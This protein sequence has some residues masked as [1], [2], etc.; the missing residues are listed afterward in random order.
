MMLDIQSVTEEIQWLGHSIAWWNRWVIGGMAATALAAAILV[1]AQLMVNRESKALSDGQD[2][3]LKLKDE[4]LANELSDKGLLIAQANERAAKAD[5]K[6]AEANRG[7]EEARRETAKLSHDAAL[8]SERTGKLELEAETQ[9]KLT[10][11]ATERAKKLELE[12]V[13]LKTPRTLIG[14]QQARM[15][16]KLR[17]Y[18]GTP[19]DCFVHNDPEAIE[20]MR[21][22]SDTL[23]AAGWL[24]KP[25][26]G[27]A[28]VFNLPGK[29]PAGIVTFTGL[30]IQIDESRQSDWAPTVRA[31]QDS[32]V[33]EGLAVS[34]LALTDAS[35]HPN[36]IHIKIGKKP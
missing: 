6:A 35:E 10:A 14:E 9:R 27:R 20:L 3:L 15:A 34:V 32:L 16:A 2:R 18:V 29:P 28:V 30:E 12:L 1:I 26:S 22:I 11:E 7:L 17:P 5:E 13:R 8:A 33:Q 31:L 25:V 4:K 21:Q 19:F 23:T 24:H 36:A